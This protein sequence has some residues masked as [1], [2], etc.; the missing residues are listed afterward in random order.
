MAA[1]LPPA[2]AD[3][4]GLAATD[5]PALTA[6]LAEAGAAAEAGALEGAVLAAA[7]E[8]ETEAVPP[9]AASTAVRPAPADRRR[10]PRRPIVPAL[11]LN[12]GSPLLCMHSS[13]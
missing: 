2:A 12:G 13:S 3:A 1:A 7:G 9:Q 8:V 5:D 10:K 11:A 6:G 4:A